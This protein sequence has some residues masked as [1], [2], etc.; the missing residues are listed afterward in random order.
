MFLIGD[1]NSRTSVKSDFIDN[2]RPAGI[3]NEENEV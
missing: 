1:L 3:H 2:D